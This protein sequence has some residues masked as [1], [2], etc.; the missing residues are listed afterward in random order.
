M[1]VSAITS[2]GVTIASVEREQDQV[3]AHLRRRV[4]R[5]AERFVAAHDERDGG[6]DERRPEQAR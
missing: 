6:E 2:S 4:A 1:K 3:G 5:G